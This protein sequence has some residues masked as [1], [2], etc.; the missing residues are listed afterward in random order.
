MFSFFVLVFKVL[1]SE[2][3]TLGSDDWTTLWIFILGLSYL[4]NG[5]WTKNLFALSNAS[6][7]I[8]LLGFDMLLDKLLFRSKD[9]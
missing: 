8:K 7:S 3:L 1:L 9:Y 5:F 2:V 4:C 6:S